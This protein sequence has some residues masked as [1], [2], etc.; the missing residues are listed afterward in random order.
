M[1][2]KIVGT[3]PFGGV[4]PMPDP[5]FK[6]LHEAGV[7]WVRLRFLFPY[8][9]H[10][11]GQWN[12][13]FLQN[14]EV[15]KRFHENGFKIMGMSFRCGIKTYDNIVGF[16]L[17]KPSTPEW[18]GSHESDEYYENVKI[19]CRDI[20]RMTADMVDIFQVSNEMDIEPFRGPLSKEQAARY[21][22]AAA[23]GLKEGNPKAKT[24]INP[25]SPYGDGEWLLKELYGN[26]KDGLW[27][28]SGIDGYFGGTEPGSPED[29]KKLIDRV[30]ELTK[31]PV[32]MHEWGYSSIGGVPDPNVK[33]VCEEGNWMNAWKNEHSE[34]EQGEYIDTAMKIFAEHPNLAG[35]FFFCWSDPPVCFSCGKPKCP[36]ECGWG[37]IDPD[38]IPKKSYGYLQNAIKNYF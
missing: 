36:R 31:T 2:N 23:T 38:G 14:M 4:V 21:L 35:E 8:V 9:D 33:S 11:G 20:G 10:M 34:Q 37:V 30:Y 13:I 12:K 3:V 1:R 18:V 19:A 24:S 7:E 15:A 28:Y 17:W 22:R 29:Y 26:N 6:L 5:D 16:R 25:A 27:D 32:I